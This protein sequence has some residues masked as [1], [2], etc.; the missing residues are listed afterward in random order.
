MDADND[1]CIVELESPW[2]SVERVTGWNRIGRLIWRQLQVEARLH[3]K[4]ADTG[5]MVV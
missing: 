1:K 4:L 3:C 2:K 5:K